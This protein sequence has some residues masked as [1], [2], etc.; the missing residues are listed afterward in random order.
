ML[1]NTFFAV[2]TVLAAAATS[3]AAIM[4]SADAGVDTPNMAGFKTFTI[5][6]TSSVSGETVAGVDLIGDKDAPVDPATSRGIFGNMNQVVLF[7]GALS[8]VFQDNNAVI[9]GTPPQSSLQDSQFLFATNAP[10]GAV[11]SPS[12][13][14]RESATSLQALFS[15]DTGFGQ[16]FPLAQIVANPS[17]AASVNVRGVFAVNQGGS[18]VDLPQ[19][20]QVVTLGGGGGP[21]PVVNLVNLGERELSAGTIVSALSATNGP[22]TGW[23]NLTLTS[24]TPAIAPT[25]AADGTFTWNPA[26]SKA[27]KKGSGQVVYSWSA[28]ATNA[29]GDSLLS[30]AITV[31][32]IPEPASMSLLGLAMVGAFG[33]IRRR[34]M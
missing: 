25:L 28:I 27:G 13:F 3:Q 20:S 4:L 6:A 23:K 9:N 14:A 29:T 16:S 18:I 10:T 33:C 32:L 11:N 26:G 8:T 5:T 12:G 31:T 30:A 7:G 19:F 24:G 34:V 21:V 22:I 2:L 15:R 17:A 1:R